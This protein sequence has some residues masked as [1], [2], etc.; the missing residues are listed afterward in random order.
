MKEKSRY[1]PVVGIVSLGATIR[2]LFVQTHPCCSD[3]RC[4]PAGICAMLWRGFLLSL[5]RSGGLVSLLCFRSRAECRRHQRRSPSSF[6]GLGE[7]FLRV[8][9]FR[10]MILNG[11][12]WGEKVKVEGRKCVRG[13][14]IGL[15]TEQTEQW[16]EQR[17]VKRS[18]CHQYA[19]PTTVWCLTM[20]LMTMMVV[21]VR[22]GTHH[23]S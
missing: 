20:M 1:W 17:K 8:Y 3:A 6:L 11:V 4:I 13:D 9:H 19:C 10:V 18:R 7:A 2:L 12:C 16:L 5:R 15:F 22:R 14:G 23:V 21:V